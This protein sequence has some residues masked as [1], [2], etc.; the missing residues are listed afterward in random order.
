MAQ[1]NLQDGHFYQ[2]DM[3]SDYRYSNIY[4]DENVKRAP[5]WDTLFNL[6]TKPKTNPNYEKN[7]MYYLGGPC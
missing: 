2:F 3:W 6:L 1:L 5:F 4:F 7:L